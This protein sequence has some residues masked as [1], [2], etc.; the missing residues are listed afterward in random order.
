MR[1]PIGKQ[2]VNAVYIK[3]RSNKLTRKIWWET[4]YSDSLDM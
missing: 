1:C 3:L 4:E 2:M